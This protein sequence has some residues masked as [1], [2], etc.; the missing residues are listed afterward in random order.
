MTARLDGRQAC[1]FCFRGITRG[2]L[3]GYRE[4]SPVRRGWALRVIPLSL[5]LSRCGCSVPMQI[6]WL[7]FFSALS[8]SC[9]LTHTERKK[10]GKNVRE[11]HIRH[12]ILIG[13]ALLKGKSGLLCCKQQ[14]LHLE[15][16]EHPPP[17]LLRTKD[18]LPSSSGRP[19]ALPRL[20]FLVWVLSL[21]D[22]EPHLFSAPSLAAVTLKGKNYSE[23]MGPL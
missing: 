6:R 2:C 4:G 19:S 10:N 15:G 13:P 16:L 18:G 17:C 23:I 20:G 14:H 3:I 8:R 5:T 11:L 7:A 12:A 9:T 22:P 1:G 21:L